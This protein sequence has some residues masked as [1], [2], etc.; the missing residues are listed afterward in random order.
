MH[1]P[2]EEAYTTTVPQ[3]ALRRDPPSRAPKSGVLHNPTQ[4]YRFK[5]CERYWPRPVA[6]RE[7]EYWL[8]VRSSEMASMKHVALGL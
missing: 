7:C 2:E 1:A 6:N 8:T 4:A 3:R 5:R